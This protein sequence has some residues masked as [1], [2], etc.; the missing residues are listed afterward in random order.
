M[1]TAAS[2]GFG[3]KDSGVGT[4]NGVDSYR[5]YTRPRS[6]VI[7]TAGQSVDWFATTEDLR[8]S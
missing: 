7:G 6:V 2:I 5:G 4:E 3:T 8:Y 1:L